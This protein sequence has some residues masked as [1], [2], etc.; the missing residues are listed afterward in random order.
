MADFVITTC[1]GDP[2]MMAQDR[3]RVVGYWIK[4]ARVCYGRPSGVRIQSL[5]K[6]L[7][8]FISPQDSTLR[9]KALHGVYAL[10]ARDTLTLTFSPG[11]GRLTFYLTPSLGWAKLHLSMG[12][13]FGALNVPSLS[14]CHTQEGYAR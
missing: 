12:V 2:N 9:S 11:G 10:P 7:S 1:F 4:V 13:D 14:M 8:S 6:C 5:E 3:A